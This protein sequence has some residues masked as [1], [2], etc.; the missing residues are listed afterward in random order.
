MWLVC[1]CRASAV[2]YINKNQTV[3]PRFTIL[4]TYGNPPIQQFQHGRSARG[5]VV[6]TPTPAL[7]I[8]F[9]LAVCCRFVEHLACT[10][11]ED[12]PIRRNVKLGVLTR[13]LTNRTLI[14]KKIVLAITPAA[15][16]ALVD[17]LAGLGDQPSMVAAFVGFLSLMYKHK[18]HEQALGQRALQSYANSIV[19]H[20]KRLLFD[21][22][23]TC[24]MTLSSALHRV[25]VL[26]VSQLLLDLAVGQLPVHEVRPFYVK[27]YHPHARNHGDLEKQIII[28]EAL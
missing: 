14:V 15:R 18:L 19:Q 27:L 26:C 13:A 6:N 7:L 10:Q 16:L 4:S 17:I 1:S 23:C 5:N 28:N 11:T 21:T 25:V 3:M 12:N 22:G 24:S 9:L 20:R 8:L 2:I